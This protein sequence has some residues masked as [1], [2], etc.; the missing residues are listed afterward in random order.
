MPQDHRKLEAFAIID[1]LALEVYR[2]TASMPMSERF[3]LQS[4]LR[5]AALRIPVHIMAGCA[6][7]S[8]QEYVLLLTLAHDVSA[9]LRYLLGLAA[10]LELIG[11]QD[12]KLLD[13]QAQSLIRALRRLIDTLADKPTRTKTRAPSMKMRS[14]SLKP[15]T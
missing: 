1:E 8:T 7:R 14:P 3:G 10:R 9:E 15:K 13:H 6:R 12:I 5:S 2:V 11:A 4:Q